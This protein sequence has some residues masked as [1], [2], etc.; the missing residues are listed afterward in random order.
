MYG[1]D[2]DD[3][4]TLRDR[5]PWMKPVDQIPTVFRVLGTGPTMVGKSS[6]HDETGTYVSAHCLTVLFVPVLALGA[7][8]VQ[9]NPRGGWFF[10]GKEP[11][12]VLSWCGN[13]AS[14]LLFLALVGAGVW[15]ARTG[16]SEY[17][18]GVRLAK[19]QQL[20]TDG[21]RAEA[22]E[23]LGLILER[24]TSHVPAA[25]ELLAE[26]VTKPAGDEQD[27][28][29]FRLAAIQERKGEGVVPDLFKKGYQAADALGAKDPALAL[30][31]LEVVAPLA[32]NSA[33]SQQ[34]E[35]RLVEALA[36]KNPADVALTSRLAALLATTGASNA[37]LRAMLV[38]HEEKLGTLDGAAILGQVYADEGKFEQP[39]RLLEPFIDARLQGY[40][41]ATKQVLAA[42]DV[43]VKRANA[44][45]ASGTAVGFDQA[46]FRAASR[47]EK[48][49][50]F[51]AFVDPMIVEDAG[52]RVAMHAHQRERLVQP[53]VLALG[54][55]QLSLAQREAA[56]DARRAGLEKAKATFFKVRE[57]AAANPQ[58]RLHLA[59]VHYW[60]G[61]AA[62]GRQ[63][64]DAY[65]EQE[66]RSAAA[67]SRVVG[68]L[69]NVGAVTEGR[70]LVE[71]AYNKEPHKQG[72]QELAS[73][74]A[75][76]SLDLDDQIVWLRRAN[77]EDFEVKA[78]LAGCLGHQAMR[79]G[80][81]A[82]AAKH[83]REQVAQ[84]PDPGEN[85]VLL[86]N[87]A[88]AYINL[89][90]V[91]LD[92]EAFREGLRR[93]EKASTLSPTD[94]IIRRVY[95][96]LLLTAAAADV[97]GDTIDWKVLRRRPGLDLLGHLYHD[98]AGWEK[99]AGRLRAS[100]HLVQARTSLERLTVLAP[101]DPGHW[102]QLASLL[103]RI[104]DA[105]ALKALAARLEGQ[106]LDTGDNDRQSR[107]LY[108]GKK[109]AQHRADARGP[110]ARAEKAL[111]A[112]RKVKGP[113]LAAAACQLSA[114]LLT[115]AYYEESD[116]DRPL[117]LAE[118]AHA[119]APSEATRAALY[120]ARLH[121][122]SLALRKEPSFAGPAREGR[123]SLGSLL[124]QWALVGGGEPRK[125]ALALDDVK[126]AVRIKAEQIKT[127]P[128]SRH[129]SDW[130][131]LAGHHPEADGLA[132]RILAEGV[133]A[134]RLSIHA[135]TTPLA[136]VTA[137]EQ[138][139]LRRMEGKAAEAKALLDERAGKG[140]P[141]PVW[142]R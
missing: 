53:A 139:W 42:Q 119:A 28:A 14:L 37:D 121:R 27:E 74:R 141:L 90:D 17:R 21:Q 19:A 36:K 112:A 62:E 115:L 3:R 32:L 6:Y 34:L 65:L 22:A 104:D 88:L 122:A 108:E 101:N 35:R 118:E 134:A 54:L 25:R 132:K 61:E 70:Q 31:L 128:G 59:R 105:D 69:R 48:E 97:F 13:V 138:A 106:N 129:A 67:V 7:Y 4:L 78:A 68:L 71:E 123:R 114:R 137:A 76:L 98:A 117:K 73:T 56:P 140:V 125:R 29:A 87:S 100:P 44:L 30:R 120:S 126:E 57:Q 39:A 12:S 86:H 92:L 81:D 75:V 124:V 49:A 52:V 110:V 113:T 5:F 33:E 47:E 102:S 1:H 45:I 133:E 10:L 23:L 41:D 11:L 84:Y 15:F 91:T 103:D 72:K 94:P 66:K 38:P 46:K 96:G 116:A 136:A 131:L 85:P 18:D 2:D 130:A 83:Y 51:W 24:K 40:Q 50:M 43:V 79:K 58:Y 55:S 107:E 99:A 89:Y 26:M 64:L 20:I 127:L 135:R 82:Q 142:G 109:D 63:L 8:R 77:L 93:S 95:T 60:L 16:S 9:D 111:E 80:D